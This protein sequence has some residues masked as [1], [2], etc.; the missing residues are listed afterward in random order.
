MTGAGPAPYD[1]RQRLAVI[2]ADARAALARGCTYDRASLAVYCG[3]LEALLTMACDS[4][5]R[6]AGLDAAKVRTS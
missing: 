6:V 5:E 2:I 1:E 4:A 3:K